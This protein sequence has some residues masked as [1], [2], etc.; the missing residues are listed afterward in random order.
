MVAT[1]TDPAFTVQINATVVGVLL[2]GA[3]NVSGS[4]YQATSIVGVRVFTNVSSGQAQTSFVTRLLPVV[5]FRGNDN[6]F[7]PFNPATSGTLDSSG[8]SFGLSP[9]ATFVM[10]RGRASLLNFSDAHH[11]WNS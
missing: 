11:Q 3:G 4:Q 6:L 7:L 5:S 10:K 9:A 2:S 1:F 8:L